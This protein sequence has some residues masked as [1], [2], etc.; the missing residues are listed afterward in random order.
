[1]KTIIPMSVVLMDDLESEGRNVIE[2]TN[3][4]EEFAL[5]AITAG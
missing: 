3:N 2:V 4:P 1:M 5:A